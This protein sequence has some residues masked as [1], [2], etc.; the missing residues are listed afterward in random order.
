MLFSRPAPTWPASMMPLA[1]PVMTMKPASAIRRPNST[2]CWYAGSLWRQAG[3]AE[4]RDLAAIAIGREHLEGV[5]QLLEGR[6]EQL[7]VAA[8]GVV[9][10]ELVG[11]FLDLLDQLFDA[12]TAGGPRR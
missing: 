6:A 12:D 11:R 10:D 9:A 8:I 4:H 7:D 2:A 3:R 1:A 5:A